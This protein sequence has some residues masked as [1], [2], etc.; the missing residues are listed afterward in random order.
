M[1]FARYFK[2]SSY[3]LIAAGFAAI[4]A[5]GS[6]DLFS[7][8]LFSIVLAISWYLDTANV[9]RRISTRALNCVSFAYLIFFA[10]DYELLSHSL[11]LALIHLI[12]FS[13]AIKL[14]TISKD[15]D[16]LLLYLISFA[17]L[18]AASTLTANIVFGI[19]FLLFLISG[20]SALALFEMSRSNAILREQV[21]VQPM[22]IPQNLRGTGWELFFPFPARLLSVMILGM[23][24]LI[25]AI[26]VPVFFLLPRIVFGLHKQPSGKAQFMSGFSDHIELGRIGVIK[27]SNAVVM[28][29]KLTKP[30]SELPANLKWRG[31]AFD[32]Y[33][34]R[35][36]RRT[37]PRLS[38]AP[39][40]GQ[41][42]KLETSAQGTNVLFQ[43]FFVE[44]LST[45][46]VFTAHKALA[47]SSDIGRLQRDPLDSLHASR[48]STAKLRYSAV[49]DLIQPNPQ[50]ALNWE[51]VPPRS[52]PQYLQL[53]GFDSRIARLA[54]QA[55]RESAGRYEKT[56]ALERYLQ[57]NYQYSLDLQEIPDSQDPVSAFLFETRKGHCEYFASAMTIM[58]RS[59]GIPARLVI[60][61]RSGEYN[62]IGDN[63]I[64]RQ[65]DAH[66]W[67]E[68]YI[69][70]Y[71]WIEFDPTAPDPQRPKPEIIRFLSNMADAL[72][73]WW[74]ESI[75]NYDSYKQYR[76]IGD[77]RDAADAFQRR[78]A[79]LFAY[80][81]EN[82]RSGASQLNPEKLKS[83]R[84]YNKGIWIPA[85]TI[86]LIVL[87]RKWRR[88]IFGLL[89]MTIRNNPSLAACSF[90]MDALQ[91]LGEK[92]MKRSRGQTPLEFA[93][94]L[95]L[96]PASEHFLALTHMYNAARFAAPG[97]VLNSSDAEALLSLLRA[98]LRK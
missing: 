38:E 12:L 77:M 71:G 16:Y 69:P 78:S 49:S 60:G 25:I 6:I 50:N 87:V 27:R 31:L 66:S 4:A 46:V 10:I 32:Y 83:I 54:M 14:L 67:V 95:Q 57:S 72:D 15:R 20:V 21:T 63:W 13:A 76:F 56:R 30:V 86:I 47:V 53:P 36:W 37:D 59:L 82:I 89:R 74:W 3:C 33:D 29:V 41:F 9:R 92:G 22:V 17:E 42:Y 85:A 65:Y 90:Y 91:L 11:I 7:T 73:L 39:I 75:V 64:V 5:T 34:G 62:N 97:T 84:I 44:A 94:T 96:Y 28:R 98:S 26:A 88:R 48:S 18:L 51:S 43:T 61:F 80:A 19:C 52:L 70:P 1:T 8:I 55:T 45:D 23:T 24:L 68:A 40:Q 58:L 81:L 35:S 93:H 2:A 79:S